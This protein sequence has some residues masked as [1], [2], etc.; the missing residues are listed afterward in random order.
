MSLFS[1]LIPPDAVV[2]EFHGLPYIQSL[3]AS[4]A[5]VLSGAGGR[6][7]ALGGGVT[8]PASGGA[9][10][11]LVNTPRQSV[12][13]MALQARQSAMMAHAAAAGLPTAAVAAAAASFAHAGGA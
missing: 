7:V 10:A 11:A 5:P 2:D 9:A 4:A 3:R 13:I 1:S 6:R 12:G 8:R